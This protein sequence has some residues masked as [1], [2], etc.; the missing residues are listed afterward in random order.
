ML[1]TIIY[2]LI[3]C[4][5]ILYYGVGINRL[6]TLRKD[7]KTF[8]KSICKSLIITVVT[9]TFTFFS[10]KIA[11]A[12]LGLIELFPLVSVLFFA[13][14]SYFIHSVIKTT[15][16]DLT[17]DYAVPY[18]ISMISILESHGILTILLISIS[19]V[20]G[21]YITGLLLASFRYRFCLYEKNQ[22]FKPLSILLIGLALL[23]IGLYSWN[24]SWLTI[25]IGNQF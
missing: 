7:F 17:E 15:P 25:G 8:I 10:I 11:L 16:M 24:A 1:S 18:L 23:F 6:L 12:P 20:A 9:S 2:Y 3:S 5:L 4:S 13:G 19:G 22:G 14:I 21:F